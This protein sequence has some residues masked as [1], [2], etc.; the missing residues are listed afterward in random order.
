MNA[1]AETAATTSRE[2]ARARARAEWEARRKAL[3]GQDDYKPER[4]QSFKRQRR[5]QRLRDELRSSQSSKARALTSGNKTVDVMNAEAEADVSASREKARRDAL[6]DRNARRRALKG[7]NDYKPEQEESFKRQ[8]RLQKERADHLKKRSRARLSRQAKAE[9]RDAR[10]EKI[11]KLTGRIGQLAKPALDLFDSCEEQLVKILSRTGW[12]RFLDDN[13]SNAK[14]LFKNR[15]TGRV[16][17]A[18]SVLVATY[19]LWRLYKYARL[20]HKHRALRRRER[21]LRKM[22]KPDF[23]QLRKL[24]SEMAKVEQ[25]KQRME[26]EAEKKVVAAAMTSEAGSVAEKGKRSRIERRLNAETKA[27]LGAKK[28]RVK[29]MLDTFSAYKK[30]KMN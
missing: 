14:F 17:V 6:E 30:N 4:E 7:Q 20:W 3:K 21:D 18:V 29:S 13:Q 19:G 5:Q 10:R 27:S 23:R 15:T 22:N 26:K 11:E 9:A 16:V 25:E 1:S 28:I 2:A 8:Q 12:K 24:K